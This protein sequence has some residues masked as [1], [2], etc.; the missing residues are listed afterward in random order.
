MVMDPS[1]GGVFAVLSTLVKW[2]LGGSQGNGNQRVS[3]IHIDDFCRALDFIIANDALDGA[4]NVCSPNPVTNRDFMRDLRRARGVSW[5]LPAMAWMLEIGAVFMRTE[6]ELLLK[7]RWV[8]PKRLL[9]AG[10]TF[11]HPTWREAAQ[12]LAAT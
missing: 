4:V 3:W 1:A 12:A 8:V 5:G 10:F 9:D 2:R 7:S 11:H 6:T